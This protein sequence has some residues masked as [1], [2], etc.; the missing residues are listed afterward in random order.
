MPRQLNDELQIQI[1]VKWAIQLV[2]FVAT[3][4][5]AWYTINDSIHNNANEI[6]HIKESLIEYEELLDER[7]SRL[8]KYKEQEL[9]EVNRSLL[10]KVLGKGE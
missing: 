1:S 8:E 9:E 5:G 10:S 4:T 3:L 2:F 7:V 6:N